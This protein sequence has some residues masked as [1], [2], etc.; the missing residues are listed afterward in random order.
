MPLGRRHLGMTILERM[1]ELRIYGSIVLLLVVAIARPQLRQQL[2]ILVAALLAFLAAYRTVFWPATLPVNQANKNRLIGSFTDDECYRNLRWRK[3]DLRELCTFLRFPLQVQLDNGCT[4]P[5]EHA[6]VLMMYRDHYPSTLFG[7]QDKF[8]RE[9]TQLSRIYN[10]AIHF[11]CDNHAFRVHDNIGWYSNRYDM[12]NLA[13]RTKI[14]ASAHNPMPGQVPA[15][16]D[17]IFASLDCTARPICRP[18]VSLRLVSVFL[19]LKKSLYQ[20]AFLP[21]FL[22]SSRPP[23]LP[24][25]L[26]LSLSPSLSLPPSFFLSP[27]LPPSQPTCLP[28][29]SGTQ[30]RSVT[31]FQPLSPWSLFDLAGDHF[32]RWSGSAQRSRAR[33]LRRRYGLARLSN[34]KRSRP[35]H[36]STRRTGARQV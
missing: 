26:P 25:F 28:P 32:P 29:P 14:A 33:L 34:E 4:F 27:S 17:D 19:N 13:Y 16:L 10:W 1:D 20:I 8:G 6:F 11:V 35:D 12:Y 24:S 3:E 18:F 7:L 31:F 30:Q 23:F 9:E 5:G 21:S 36:E 2:L 22:P 15:N